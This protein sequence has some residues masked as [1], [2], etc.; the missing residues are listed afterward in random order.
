MAESVGE[1]VVTVV[2]KKA[3]GGGVQ[4]NAEVTALPLFRICH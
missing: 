2:A 3:N 4:I 1:I